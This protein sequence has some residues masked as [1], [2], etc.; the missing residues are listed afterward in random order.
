MEVLFVTSA[1]LQ[2][3]IK[4]SLLCFICRMYTVY[5]LTCNLGSTIESSVTRPFS[6][7]GQG[8]SWKRFFSCGNDSHSINASLLVRLILQPF[9][10]S[11]SQLE[12]QEEKE[13]RSLLSTVQGNSITKGRIIDWWDEC[14]QRMEPNLDTSPTEVQGEDSA[15]KL[16]HQHFIVLCKAHPS[17]YITGS[18]KRSMQRQRR[19][20]RYMVPLPSGLL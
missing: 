17:T 16:P 18:T 9:F 14:N 20:A 3:I 7:Q 11:V 8:V 2:R 10:C 6:G 19:Q 4:L 12:W 5:L 15:A 13:G 1:P